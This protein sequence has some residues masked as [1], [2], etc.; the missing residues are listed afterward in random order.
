MMLPKTRVVAQRWELILERQGV[1][2]WKPTFPQSEDLELIVEAERR[3]KLYTD[4]DFS[5]SLHFGL[6]FLLK[7]PF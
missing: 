2:A 4:L 7:M 5:E 1:I 6:F 3:I